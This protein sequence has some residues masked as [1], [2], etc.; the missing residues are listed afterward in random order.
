[1]PHEILSGT[2]TLTANVVIELGYAADEHRQAL[3]ATG[4]VLF[5]F[6]MGINIAFS[7]LKKK[8]GL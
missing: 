5:V 4:V 1:M 2:R 7:M 8:D 3:I 6:I